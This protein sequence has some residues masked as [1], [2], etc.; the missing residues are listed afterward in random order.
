MRK[1]SRQADRRL[2]DRV[3][4]VQWNG[5]GRTCHRRRQ[6]PSTPASTA[7]TTAASGRARASAQSALDQALFG[8]NL[9]AADRRQDR[10]HD[11]L[12]RVGSR[13]RQPEPFYTTA[14]TSVEAITPRDPRGL[15]TITSDGKYLPDLGASIP[16]LENGGVV[17]TGNTF[18]V[19]ATLR[20][21]LEWSDGTAADD[22]RLEGHLAVRRRPGPARLHPVLAVPGRSAALTSRRTACRRRSTSRSSTRAG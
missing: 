6:R 18:T 4:R 22:E 16:T 2:G 15:L 12:R 3:C 8:T 7:P 14:F 1:P 17:I 9:Q 21:G 10:W 19:A 11:R 20:P 5:N 13:P